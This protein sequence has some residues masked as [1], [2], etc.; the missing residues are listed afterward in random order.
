MHI[1]LIKQIKGDIYEF[2]QI[3]FCNSIGFFTL[4]LQFSNSDSKEASDL[5][6]SVQKASASSSCTFTCL[7]G[8]NETTGPD[9]THRWICSGGCFCDFL[10]VEFGSFQKGTCNISDPGQI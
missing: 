10:W 7:T 9:G 1:T 4:T 6:S 2:N 5:N 3:F 8:L